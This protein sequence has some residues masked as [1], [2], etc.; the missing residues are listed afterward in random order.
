MDSVCN[1]GRVG[2][3]AGLTT[4]SPGPWYSVL[5]PDMADG[6]S[7]CH[8]MH[9]SNLLFTGSNKQ[10]K[11][12]FFSSFCFLCAAP[13]P[14]TPPRPNF[15]NLHFLKLIPTS[16]PTPML[17]I[18]LSYWVGFLMPVFLFHHTVLFTDCGCLLPFSLTLVFVFLVFRATQ[19]T[20]TH[21]H[22]HERTRTGR[23]THTCEHAHTGA[24]AHTHA[25]THARARTCSPSKN[26][27][28]KVNKSTNS[29]KA[30]DAHHWP[31][32]N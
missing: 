7:V 27:K 29:R 23:H 20:H 16:L 8:T 18:L 30:T 1:R 2:S 14:S 24:Y 11:Y 5:L 21:T 4:P 3:K 19:Y 12:L 26:T 32:N 10:N 13:P 15:L 28:N 17:F 9:S 31:L 22:T 25:H 6:D